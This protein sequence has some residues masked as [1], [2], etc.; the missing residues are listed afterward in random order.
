MTPE[1]EH[2]IIDSSLPI[3]ELNNPI[4]SFKSACDLKTNLIIIQCEINKDENG[5]PKK[6]TELYGIRYAQKLRLEGYKGKI[7]FISFLSIDQILKLNP[8]NA[9]IN[10][11]GHGF[12]RLPVKNDEFKNS[13]EEINCLSDIELYDIQSNYCN[14]A[15]IAQEI[16]HRLHG[17]ATDR[18]F[19]LEFVKTE[20]CT[21]V[22]T[23]GSL[24]KTDVDPFVQKLVF[25][26]LGKTLNEVDAY[27]NDIVSSVD[28]D[29]PHNSNNIK[30]RP[31][32]ILFLDDDIK[33]DHGL[34]MKLVE[35]VENVYCYS[36]YEEA[37]NKL[38][39]N[40]GG[41][42]KINLVISDYRLIEVVGETGRHQKKQGYT[43]LMESAEKYAY[44]GLAALSSLP[45][46]FL[47]QSFKRMGIKT[48]IYSKKD[49]LVNDTTISML[50][51]EL[52]EIGDD[53][54]NAFSRHIRLSSP[55]WG[56]Y[57]P[58][59]IYHRNSAEYRLNESYIS[60][61]AKSYCV[62]YLE[63]KP[64]FDLSGYTTELKGKTKAPDNPKAFH[65]FLEKMI[66][67]RAVLWYSQYGNREIKYS[68]QEVIAFLQGNNYNP[69]LSVDA[70]TNQIN[71]NLA[72]R[73]TD[74]PW[75]ATWEEREWLINYMNI[76]RSLLEEIETVENAIIDVVQLRFTSYRSD[77]TP[78]TISNAKLLI[79]E[80]CSK[81]NEASFMDDIL[82]NI[83]VIRNRIKE[84]EIN[85]QATKAV[86]DFSGYLLRVSARLE[87]IAKAV[88]SG[89][90]PADLD[91][92]K[93]EVVKRAEKKFS[94]SRELKE[95]IEV[96]ALLFFA[97]L[98]DKNN[99]F[100]N[101]EGFVE[102]FYSFHKESMGYINPFVT[103]SFDN[104]DSIDGVL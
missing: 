87:K 18:S 37:E 84:Y 92:I 50:I 100:G 88:R 49:Y 30:K 63:R 44:L 14:R 48:A 96:S 39:E 40:V 75:N 104:F 3:S 70:A 79:S 13:L 19:T 80:L 21:A 78:N 16:L 83:S 6:R 35:R 85:D 103:I 29:N 66:C 73:L 101:L 58:F 74:F 97:E 61:K 90:L 28:D 12:L 46:K 95:G 57:E 24:Y 22:E 82:T 23:I 26:D 33:A 98:Q 71:T 60:N 32:S 64:N 99:T 55:Q 53:C 27:C 41:S 72:L 81:V 31:W 94:Y 4:L 36:N 7:L 56:N 8:Q 69:S 54:Y 47:I 42:L 62:N 25:D 5:N 89:P 59:Y 77:I 86:Q 76:D 51:D 15:G 91:K 9:I 93:E 17:F 34:V 67:R 11:I 10:A 68:P 65:E 2:I 20:I 43:F 38:R 45:R 1:R 52:L 102:A